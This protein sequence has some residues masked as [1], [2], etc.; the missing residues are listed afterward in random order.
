MVIA[1]APPRI[2][3]RLRLNRVECLSPPALVDNTVVTCVFLYM[4]RTDR[5]AFRQYILD[6]VCGT[7]GH[8]RGGGHT[9]ESAYVRWRL[10]FANR[11]HASAERTQDN[12][13][14]SV[15]SRSECMRC[16]GMT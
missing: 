16:V 9:L 5:L 11:L 12:I 8:A 6:R 14:G 2:S 15:H 1:N 7:T 3:I 10:L 4:V 13:S